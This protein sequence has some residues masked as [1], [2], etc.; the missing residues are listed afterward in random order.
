[1][2]SHNARRLIDEICSLAA[3]LEKIRIMEVCGTH[4]VSLFRSGIRTVLPANL[5]LVSGPGCP[6]CVTS[7]GYIDS[8][9]EAA[10]RPDVTVCTYGDMLRVPG[11]QGSLEQ[12]RAGGARVIVCYS[13]RDGIAYAATH[14]E[15]QVIFLAVGFETT[16]PATALAVLEAD[17]R[18]LDNF[19]VLNGHKTVLPALEFLLRGGDIP[20]DGFL[21]PGHVSVI[22]GSHA[23]EE[24][25][26]RYGKACVVTGFEPVQ[27]LRGILSLVRQIAANEPRVDNVYSVAVT[28]E[29]N[30]V[31]LD[32]LEEVFEPAD[33]VWRAIGRIAMSGYALRPA[34]RKF[35]AE[36]RF[37]LAVDEDYELP[38]C[39]CGEVIQGRIDPPECSLFGRA[40]TREHPVGPCMVSSEGTCAAWHR[41]ALVERSR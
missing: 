39:R 31:A 36:K 16:A 35:D 2:N 23:F 28:R 20:I 34:L 9:I 11:R 6:V 3:D 25:A 1:M 10:Q 24:V 27:M 4:T 14:P 8:A 13:I 29:G 40:C 17:T 26:E 22:T 30:R 37:G 7:Q 38:G 5:R 18:G 21:L 12:Q 41:Y 19:T 33:V 32:R 15:E